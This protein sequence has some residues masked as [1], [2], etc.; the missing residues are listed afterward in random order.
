MEDGL[1][2]WSDFMVQFLKNQ[3]TKS[4]GLSLHVNRMWT[5]RNDHAP[6]SE[7]VF[8]FIY[9]LKKGKFEKFRFDHSFVF[10]YLHLLFLPQ[11][12][13][14]KFDYNNIFLP[15]ALVFFYHST[16]FATPTTKLIGLC[17]WTMYASIYVFWGAQTS[18]S[19]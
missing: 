2:S 5:K 11:K 17:H 6:K 1:F 8:I 19:L 18:W 9:V 7:C 13:S 14:L 3:V 16:S 4:L 12:K 10:S 15:K